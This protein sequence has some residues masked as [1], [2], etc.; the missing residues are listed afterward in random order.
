MPRMMA[1]MMDAADSR[2]KTPESLVS[3]VSLIR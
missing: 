3:D 2:E 1:P